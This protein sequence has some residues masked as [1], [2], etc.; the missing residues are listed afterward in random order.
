MSIEQAIDAFWDCA[1]RH[2]A[3]PPQWMNRLSREDAYRVQLGVLARHVQAGER[4]AGWKVGLTSKAMQIQQKVHEPVLGFLLASG[5]KPSGT[6]FPFAD[7]INPGFENELCLTVGRTLRGPGVSDAQA[8]AA[9][10]A[11]APAFEI[12]EKRGDFS[13]DLNVS[14]ADNAQ[15]RAYVTGAP[16]PVPPGFD[17]AT[18][19]LELGVNGAVAERAAGAEVLGTP[20]A[21][22]AWLANKLAELG[23]ALEAGMKVMSGSFT[24]QYPLSRGDRIEASFVPV[25]PV[26]AEF[27]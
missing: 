1:C 27:V 10:S 11:M 12:I 25:G 19:T 17:L 4:Q 20:A 5:E 9:L 2:T 22:V 24:R 8:Q 23:L 26:R 16:V 13:A 14:L 18:V 21:S 3:P 15:Q 7:L 6:R